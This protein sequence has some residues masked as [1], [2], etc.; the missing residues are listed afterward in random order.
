MKTHQGKHCSCHPGACCFCAP[1]EKLKET[2]CPK[3]GATYEVAK[4][5]LDLAGK[6]PYCDHYGCPMYVDTT[7]REYH[8]TYEMR[9]ADGSHKN[10]PLPQVPPWYNGSYQQWREQHGQGR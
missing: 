10:L 2:P 3:C 9:K 5:L 4:V 7:T 6:L 1:R 8:D